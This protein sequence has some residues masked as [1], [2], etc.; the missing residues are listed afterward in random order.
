MSTS[1]Q[2]RQARSLGYDSFTHITSVPLLDFDPDGLLF[3][4]TLTDIEIGDVWWY[5][6]STDDADRVARQSI[7]AKVTAAEASATA[8]D[9][10]Y[11]E[12]ARYVARL[13]A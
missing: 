7:A 5:V 8:A 13:G 10:R 11:A 9:L 12:L 2:A 6:T 3:D 1:I 4:G